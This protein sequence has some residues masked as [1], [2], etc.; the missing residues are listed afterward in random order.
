[1]LL[2]RWIDATA[3]E[4]LLVI[5]MTLIAL[6]AVLFAL[7]IRPAWRVLQAAP[8]TLTALDA[9][10]LAMRAQ[11]AQLR[12]APIST[13]ATNAVAVTLPS[14]E[15]ELSSTGATVGEVREAASAGQATTTITLKGVESARLGVWLAHSEV[16][17]RLYSL[18]ITRD[19]TSGRVSGAVT[20]RVTY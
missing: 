1:M 18:N 10:V 5:A 12:S 9:K 8:A 20:M 16:Q 3:R 17:K 14:A 19:A 4:R 2:Q 15:R 11:A 6:C 7:L 13:N